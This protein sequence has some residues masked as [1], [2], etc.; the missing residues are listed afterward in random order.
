MRSLN[1][2]VQH[3]PAHRARVQH[4]NDKVSY[5]NKGRVNDDPAF[6][7]ILFDTNSFPK[8]FIVIVLFSKHKINN[9]KKLTK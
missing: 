4:I 6:I 7:F 8:H 1:C 9:P 5:K 3:R 2:L